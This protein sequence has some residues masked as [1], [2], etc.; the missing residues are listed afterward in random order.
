M[1]KHYW[2]EKETIR[3]LELFLLRGCVVLNKRDVDVVELSRQLAYE[4]KIEGKETFPSPNSIAMKTAN[5][6]SL[7]TG[8][9]LSHTSTLDKKIWEKYTSKLLTL[10]KSAFR[11]GIKILSNPIEAEEGSI[12]PV[13]HL[14]RERNY[15][16]IREKKRLARQTGNLRC[17][18][19]G[20]DFEK[21]YGDIGYNFIE[22]HHITPLA[23]YIQCGQRTRL[24]DLILVCSNCHR[25]L[26]RINKSNAVDVLNH[27]LKRS[28]QEH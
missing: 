16:L 23:S 6:M 19:C 14:L 24:D 21:T 11:Q 15:S 25:M 2:N 27:I 17:S 4:A 22:A 3:V 18:L 8:T 28:K 5:F 26:H 12:V 10:E 13:M 7:Y 20:F 1:I 9:G